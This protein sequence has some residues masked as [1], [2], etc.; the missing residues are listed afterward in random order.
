MPI[1]VILSFGTVSLDSIQTHTESRTEVIGGSALYFAAAASRL[2]PVHVIGPIGSDFPLDRL[3]PLA[4]HGVDLAGLRL[5]SGSSLRWSARY[6]ATGDHR[7]TLSSDRTILAGYGPILSARELACTSLFVGSTNPTLQRSV[8]GQL[9]ARGHEARPFVVVD[10]MT[11]WI[12]EE[13]DEVWA[14][15]A[16]SDLFLANDEE[17]RALTNE[18]DLREAAGALLEVGP[19][20][21]VIK[22]GSLG[23]SAFESA[24]RTSCPA[25][26]I[27]AVD[28][29]GAGDAFAGGFVASWLTH[30]GDG[31]RLRHALAAGVVCGGQATREFSFDA[32]LKPPGDWAEE[33]H[34]SLLPR[35][36][37]N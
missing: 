18:T 24:G 34:A 20:L 37:T 22:H 6:D 32:L 16:E 2:V 15:A 28:P 30:R 26:E 11:H 36:T 12:E 10:S 29:T 23:A 33:A 1:L 7:Q 14:V 9:P 25:L 27:A 3:Q 8:V 21:V 17:I 35:M 31:D 13:P 5:C 19:S 4:E